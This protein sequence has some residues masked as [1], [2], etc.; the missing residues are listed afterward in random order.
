[1]LDTAT[2]RVAFGVVALSVLVLFYV[3][4]Y[5]TSHSAYSAWWC[6]SLAL[7]IVGATLYLFDGTEGQ[8]V[9]N[10]LGNALT[11]AGAAAVWSGTRALRDAPIRGGPV[12]AG[13]AV[14][15]VASVLDDPAGDVWTGGPFFLTAMGVLLGLA[16]RELWLLVGEV[17]GRRAEDRSVRGAVVAMAVMSGL[18]SAFYLCR[19]VAF[20]AFGADHLVFDVVLG[21]QTTTLFTLVM[22]VVVTYTM[23]ILGH[24]QQTDALRVRADSDA[25]TGLLNRGAF[26]HRLAAVLAEPGSA[27]A[28]AVVMADLDDFKSLNDRDGHGAGDRA[29]AAFGRAVADALGD[30]DVAGR[31][32]GD[33][34]AVLLHDGELAADFT[35]EV[36]AGVRRALGS[37]DS[38]TASFGVAAGWAG[39]DPDELVNRADVALYRAKTSGRDRTVWW[40]ESLDGPPRAARRTQRVPD[41]R[42]HPG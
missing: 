31:L 6:V 39:A 28:C 30:D 17:D 38:P 18:L 9:A 20:T 16:S 36:A 27:H 4:T 10:P 1:V 11:T 37:G 5:R 23:S 34:F 19:A 26:F 13:P 42:G 32:G 22:L 25:L 21:S 24:H 8:V 15:L 40:D 2:L 35:S 41:D 33:E 29:L 12:L 7:F 3:A 14:V